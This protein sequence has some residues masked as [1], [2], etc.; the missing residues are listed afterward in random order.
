MAYKNKVL[1]TNGCLQL[2]QSVNERGGKKYIIKRFHTYRWETHHEADE[3]FN[4]FGNNQVN[5]QM[6]KFSTR[7]EA[8]ELMS[9]AVLKGMSRY[10]R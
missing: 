7:K 5:S 1:L 4:R 2:I 10:E 6:W 9:I 8:E 3:L